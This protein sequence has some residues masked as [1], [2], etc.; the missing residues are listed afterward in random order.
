MLKIVGYVDS[1]RFEILLVLFVDPLLLVLDHVLPKLDIGD[2]VEL[3][4]QS[5]FVFGACA[6]SLLR[7]DL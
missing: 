3:V 6:V 1:L 2:F 5:L 4:E 7:K